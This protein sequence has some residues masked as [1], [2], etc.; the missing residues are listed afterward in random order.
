MAKMF[1]RILKIRLKI[2]TYENKTMD[3]LGYC[4]KDT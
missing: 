3:L 2:K 4:W 1:E